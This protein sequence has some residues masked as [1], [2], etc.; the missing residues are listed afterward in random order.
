MLQDPLP[1]GR[2]G[3]SYAIYSSE[4]AVWGCPAPSPG[5]RYAG[6]VHCTRHDELLKREIF[7]TLEVARVLIK[8]WRQMQNRWRPHITRHQAAGTG[9]AGCPARDSHSLQR[10]HSHRHTVWYRE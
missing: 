9:G 2:V 10:Q 1:V 3:R 7:H 8:R 5:N 6:S 4:K